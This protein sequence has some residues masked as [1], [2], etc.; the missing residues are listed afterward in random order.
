MII[1]RRKGISRS[2][3]SS[4]LLR[5]LHPGLRLDPFHDASWTL[6]RPDYGVEG[7]GEDAVTAAASVVTAVLLWRLIPMAAA[8]PSPERLQQLN[9]ALEKGIA[10]R[11]LAIAQ[12]ERERVER[13]KVEAELLQVQKIEALGHLTGGLA[14]DFNNL[15]QAVQG[16]LELIVR[17][18]G[19][20][21][22]VKRLAEG[23]LGATQR[24]AVLTA[25]LLAF[26]RKK[27]LQSD[28]FLIGDMI[29]DM[30]E[31][32]MRGGGTVIDL[33]FE[34]TDEPLL[35]GFRPNV[36]AEVGA[37]EPRGQRAAGATP[38]G[39]RIVIGARRQTVAAGRRRRSQ[40]AGVLRADFTVA[41][42]GSGM[43][44]LTWRGTGVRPVLHHQAGRE[45]ARGSA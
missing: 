27:Q 4:G 29:A 19:D 36:Q 6:W 18:A 11:D 45:K 39:G 3:G 5:G 1:R 22:S 28:T 30:R 25:K 17:R 13:L 8:L 43:D 23:G 42:T 40:A 32:L 41:D 10:E 34:L 7:A 14:H 15:L 12:Q 35:R 44:R 21:V 37:A 2:A 9:L 26:A 24:G 20:P 38:T 16:S 33:R 31:I